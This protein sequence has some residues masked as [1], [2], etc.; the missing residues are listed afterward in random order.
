MAHCRGCGGVYFCW[1]CSRSF[2]NLDAQFEALCDFEVGVD[3]DIIPPFFDRLHGSCACVC[4][5]CHLSYCDAMRLA[6]CGDSFA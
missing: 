6:L 5:L 4:H 3:A 1:W 2:S